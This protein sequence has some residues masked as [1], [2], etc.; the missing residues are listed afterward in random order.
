MSTNYQAVLDSQSNPWLSQ[1]AKQGYSTP[2]DFAAAT[3]AAGPTP[4]TPQQLDARYGAGYT[5]MP[6]Y[7]PVFPGDDGSLQSAIQWTDRQ[8]N[9]E[10]RAGLD[11]IGLALI[12]GVTGG[13]LSAAGAAG[14]AG[15]AAS[16]GG[17]AGGGGGA[18]GLD[19]AYSGIVD[20]TLA[21]A[22]PAATASGL[23]PG[24]TAGAN[25][26]PDAAAPAATAADSAAGGAA[27]TAPPAAAAAGG[28]GL[29][30]NVGKFLNTNKDLIGGL[31][32]GVGE[33]YA[34][35]AQA[36]AQQDLLQKKQ[37]L[38]SANYRGANPNA[39][40]RG[41]APNPN[42]VP[43]DQKFGRTTAGASW[44]WDYDPAQ[45]KIVKVADTGPAP[46]MRVPTQPTQQQAY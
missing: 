10:Q 44:R 23:A 46:N 14:A 11:N 22:A 30:S 32:K 21:A 19:A 42:G 33:G 3:P 7:H 35:N 41:L 13:F 26:L 29:L 25:G 24:L 39:T 12:G 43:P 15:S 6:L 4:Q 28:S 36:Q 37:D 31:V 38:I 20:P 16:A 27:I 34:A 17:A 45:G 18:A 40:F 1:L 9:S 8:M 5:T 2:A